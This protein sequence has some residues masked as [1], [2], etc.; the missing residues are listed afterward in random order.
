MSTKFLCESV[1]VHPSFPN[2]YAMQ[3]ILKSAIILIQKVVSK[4][5]WIV[6]DWEIGLIMIGKKFLDE[7]ETHHRTPIWSQPA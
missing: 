3:C 4:T 1:L 7:F 5:K 6:Q 2:A